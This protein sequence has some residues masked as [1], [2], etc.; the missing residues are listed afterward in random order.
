MSTIPE[1]VTEDQFRDYILPHL[2]TAR[3][4]YVSKTPLHG[5]FNLIL[6]RLHTGC[7]WDRLPVS[8]EASERERRNEPSWQAVY[9]HW[10]KW[11]A[12]GSL[13]RVWQG[14]IGHIKNELD[15]RQINLDGSHAIAK[16]GG[17]SVAYQARKRAKTSNILPIT[18][19][20]GY[21]IACTLI[22]AGHHN[23]AF[24]LKAHLQTAFK[25]MKRW[26]LVISGAFFNAD[27]AFD[28]REARKVCFNHHLIPNMV[29]NKRN[30]KYVKRGRKRLFNPQIYKDR[31]VSERSFA[32]IDKF[33]ALLLRFDRKDAH[34]LAGH[35]LAFALINLRH[36]F[37][38]NV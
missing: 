21:L 25:T 26:G 29:E 28:T 35:H 34:F 1:S 6:Y 4:G 17:E 20:N 12:D 2:T 9:D 36:L 24:N 3:R 27:S 22:V 19:K 5:I 30:R 23:D 18:D 38:L 13:E 33:R 10:R 16:K 11:S 31:F 8:R 7:Q 15:L 37:A 32:W 14:S